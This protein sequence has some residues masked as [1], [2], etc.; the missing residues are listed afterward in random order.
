SDWQQFLDS[1]NPLASI[2][3]AREAAARRAAMNNL[4]Q[5]G[6][7]AQQYQSQGPQSPFLPAA[8]NQQNTWMWQLLPYIEQ[9]NIYCFGPVDRFGA[10]VEPVSDATRAQIDLAQGKGLLVMDVRTDSP[11]AKAGLRKFDI[12]L[13]WDGKDVAADAGAFSKT[14]ADVPAKK[15]VNAIVLRKG[16]EVEL[17]NITLPEAG[18]GSPFSYNPI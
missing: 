11:A 9:S 7:A 16:K 15:A 18:P 5:L 10:S 4:K 13:K 14:I 12:L 1:L 6:I 3:K 2:Q 17:K 8:P